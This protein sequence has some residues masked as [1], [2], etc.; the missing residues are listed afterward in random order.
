MKKTYSND[1]RK[2][3][4]SMILWIALVLG[5]FTSCS[6]G[7]ESAKVED[8]VEEASSTN[9][10]SE[11]Q[12]AEASG[13]PDAPP[14]TPGPNAGTPVTPPPG[15][16]P[17]NNP[18]DQPPSPPGTGNAGNEEKSESEES[19]IQLS[20]KGANVDMI[21]EWLSKETGKSIIKHPKVQCQLTI[22]SSNKLPRQEALKLVYNALALEGFT[23]VETTR[24]I[25]LLPEGEEPKLSPEMLTQDESDTEGRQRIVKIFDLKHVRASEI[26]EK[27]KGVLSTNVKMESDDN[28]NKII[29]TDY[30]Q[31]IRLLTEVIEELDVVSA[32]DSVIEIIN[33]TY[34]DADELSG[35][36]GSVLGG[37]SAGPQGGRPGGRPQPPS[38]GTDASGTV[39]FWPDRTANRIIV[40]A[41][42]HRI[43]EIRTLIES[44]D[45]EKPGD[46]SIR[47]LPLINMDAADLIRE[48]GPLF[49]KL[50]TSS[51]KG[52]IEIAANSRS[53]SLI[54]LSN[55]A[56]YENI[57]ELIASLDT[58]KAQQKVVKVFPLENADA[59][60][61]AE[62]LETL[63]EGQS[64]NTNYR[65]VYYYSMPGG[66]ANEDTKMKFVAD[67][68]RN[69]VIVQGPPSGMDAIDQMITA[70]D[71][72]VSGE[73]LAP[74]IYPLKYVS[75][76][77]IEEVLNELFTEQQQQQ[78]SYW[79]Y[80]YSSS[81]SSSDSEV[82]RLY[83]KVKI[84]SES[85]SNSIIVTSNSRENLDA[86]ED[87]LKQL[88]VPSQ[89]GESTLRI[90][91]RYSKAVTIAN[92]MNI[93]FAK[94][95][96]PPLRPNQ[97]QNNQ[98]NQPNQNQQQNQNQ[99]RNFELEQE[100][101]E[102]T[103]FPWL[104]SQQDGGGGT[105]AGR[106]TTTPRPVSDLVG[107]VRIVPDPRTNSL[108]ITS[109]VHFLSQILK[110]V[111][112]MDT[113]T[114]QVLIDTKIIEVS[115]DLRD[116][117]G[118]RWSPN[119]DRV[120]DGDDMDNSLM[121][122]S[123]AVFRRIFTGTEIGDSAKSGIIS[124]SMNLD[125][126]L[127]FLRK[128]S[129]AK[130]MAE[131]QLN[132]ADN[133]IGKLFV[134]S[135]VPFVSGSNTTPQGGL[136][137]QIE[138]RNVGIILEVTPKINSDEDVAL[139]IRLEASSVRA[140]ES[141]QGS[142]IFDTREFRTDLMVQNGQTLVLGGILQSED[143]EVVRK[144]PLLGDIP[145]LGFLFKKKDQVKR[146]VELMVFLR[147][148]ITRTP[149]DVDRLILEMD[150]QV[151]K[152]M[153]WKREMENPTNDSE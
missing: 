149:A 10:V 76:I 62:Q 92:N 117:L 69:S 144:V 50:S 3:L 8:P 35:L 136:T 2:P 137:S 59:Q 40:A 103:Y 63:Y 96:S 32:S 42:Q 14:E 5:V 134:G 94:A 130:V 98:P 72:P 110:L 84:T 118:V 51:L 68:R 111:H 82:G 64:G 152:V 146:D 9:T 16:P 73:N 106:T 39:R 147:P 121:A 129:D 53:N 19:M 139:S 11:P 97:P 54:V 131:P 78:R 141:L 31:N 100:A 138:Y 44:L 66:G 115:T 17:T 105:A 80:Y 119:G 126:L 25:M 88:D 90:G 109:N 120:F 127:Q 148:T 12:P 101:K 95:G 41:P 6:P 125:I 145:I 29:V 34:S 75:A 89:A 104:G 26:I 36:L 112:E 46:L 70:L 55:Q 135:E 22:V 49:Q 87:I 47:V 24:S 23:T 143:S 30:A 153:N 116:R 58:D 85:Y 107:K 18:Q 52:I 56:N 38:G 108:L 86:L 91:I 57:K 27:L 20:F 114:A 81:G 99:D 77:D 4:V 102:E 43:S 21:V 37:S 61:V 133:E 45:T 93:L 7:S 71:E 124:T 48:I 151:P 122:G 123:E 74:K 15:G 113:P 13:S 128:N 67:R 65:Y 33:L 28:A 79:D 140:G 132:V 1:L 150:R 83:G 142:P 60:D